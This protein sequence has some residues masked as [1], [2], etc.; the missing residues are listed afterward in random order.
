MRNVQT[1]THNCV[2]L[3]LFFLAGMLMLYSV[4]FLNLLQATVDIAWTKNKTQQ[5]KETQS[6]L[7][8][9]TSRFTELVYI[10]F[11]CNSSPPDSSALYI[12][13]I[14]QAECISV[15]SDQLK[16]NKSKKTCNDRAPP[17]RTSQNHPL[18]NKKTSYI[19][20]IC[21]DESGNWRHGAQE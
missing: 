14:K 2:Q 12:K 13:G 7:R 8:K 10:F 1:E 16:L 4:T 11:F 3:S 20:I 17:E 19:V 21:V 9:L 6:K 15:S 18:V 5:V